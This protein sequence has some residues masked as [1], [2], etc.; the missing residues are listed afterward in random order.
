M[1]PPHASP[2]ASEASRLNLASA[3]ALSMTIDEY[4][5]FMQEDWR[6]E[7]DYALKRAATLVFDLVFEK[8]RPKHR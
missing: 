5:N 2:L 6:V 7:D 3:N 4:N 8:Y 1:P